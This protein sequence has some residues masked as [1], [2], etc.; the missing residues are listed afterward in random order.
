[1]TE[2]LKKGLHFARVQQTGRC[3][4]HP[5]VLPVVEA[6]SY[7]HLVER[8]ELVASSPRKL[9]LE[10]TNAYNERV[11]QQLKEKLAEKKDA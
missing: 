7:T 1:M 10:R 3:V 4:G 11:K 9:F 6:V 5:V 8:E 2:I